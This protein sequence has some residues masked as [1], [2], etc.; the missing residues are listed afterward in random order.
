MDF[1]DSDF[2]K[3]RE[4]SKNFSSLSSQKMMWLVLLTLLINFKTASTAHVRQQMYS[5]AQCLSLYM[6]D[7]SAQAPNAQEAYA[8]AQAAAVAASEAEE[9]KIKSSSL[10][11][12][13]HSVQRNQLVSCMSKSSNIVEPC[14][15]ALPHALTLVKAHL[16]REAKSWFNSECDQLK[17]RLTNNVAI[18]NNG[19]IPEG[20]AGVTAI[21]T[22]VA[23]CQ[24]ATTKLNEYLIDRDKHIEG[25]LHMNLDTMTPEEKAKAKIQCQSSQQLFKD[26]DVAVSGLWGDCQGRIAALLHRLNDAID[27]KWLYPNGI[28]D[29][30]G[31][32]LSSSSSNS[33]IQTVC[34]TLTGKTSEGTTVTPYEKKAMTGAMMALSESE[35]LEMEAHE[36]CAKLLD[37]ASKI[38]YDEEEMK[39]NVKIYDVLMKNEERSYICEPIPESCDNELLPV[40]NPTTNKCEACPVETPPLHWDPVEMKCVVRQHK[41]SITIIKLVCPGEQFQDPLDAEQCKCPD[42]RPKYVGYKGLCCKAD[43]MYDTLTEKCG[44]PPPICEGQKNHR[45]PV[46]GV[47]ECPAKLPHYLKGTCSQCPYP[48]IRYIR[49]GG[50]VDHPKCERST[51]EAG[52]SHLLPGTNPTSAEYS[53]GAT[54]VAG[55]NGGGTVSL[56]QT[57]DTSEQQRAQTMTAS[58]RSSNKVEEEVFASSA[59]GTAAEGRGQG[60]EDF[61][62]AATGSDQSPNNSPNN[63]GSKGNKNSKTARLLSQQAEDIKRG[64]SCACPYEYPH[65]VGGQC[66]NCCA[67]EKGRTKFVPDDLNDLA[68]SGRCECPNEVENVLSY[69]SGKA[70]CG[71][72]PADISDHSVKSRFVSITEGAS[73]GECQCELSHPHTDTNDKCIQ[74]RENEHWDAE[75]K[76]CSET[77]CCGMENHPA[78]NTCVCPD[79][80][81]HLINGKC[82]K[83]SSIKGETTKWVAITRTVEENTNNPNMNDASTGEN[84]KK[85]EEERDEREGKCVCPDEAHTIRLPGAD[86]DTCLICDD[87]AF[88]FFNILTMRCEV[89][90]TG[91]Q[92]FDVTTNKCACPKEKSLWIAGTCF[93][94]CPAEEQPKPEP[95]HGCV[96]KEFVVDDQELMTTKTPVKL[97]QLCKKNAMEKKARGFTLYSAT[98]DEI[99]SR[100]ALCTT[101]HNLRTEATSVGTWFLGVHGFTIHTTELVQRTNF[102]LIDE[103][104]GDGVCRCPE[105]TP[106]W[107]ELLK[108]CIKCDSEKT[109]FNKEEGMCEK[110]CDEAEGLQWNAAKQKCACPTDDEHVIVSKDG[111]KRCNICESPQDVFY[112]MVESPIV[113][114]QCG[115]PEGEE[116]WEPPVTKETPQTSEENPESSST[117]A[118]SVLPP[119]KCVKCVAPK[120][121]LDPLTGECTKE[122]TEGKVFS[123]EH[124]ICEC[125]EV[126]PCFAPDPVTSIPRC[127]KC[128]GNTMCT[129]FK[130]TSDIAFGAPKEVTGGPEDSP[131]P[132]TFHFGLSY[133]IHTF[134]SHDGGDICLCQCPKQLPHR[135]GNYDDGNCIACN[136]PKETFDETLKTCVPNCDYEGQ[137]GDECSCPEGE[138]V[139]DSSGHKDVQ[140][141]CSLCPEPTNHF[142]PDHSKQP[143]GVGTCHCPI[144]THFVD[145]ITKETITVPAC[146]A[147]TEPTSHFDADSQRCVGLCAHGQVWITNRCECPRMEPNTP[148]YVKDG[149]ENPICLLC[150]SDGSGATDFTVINEVTGE[151]ECKCPEE[152][153]HMGIVDG[154]VPESQCMACEVDGTEFNKDVQKCAPICAKGT[155][156]NKEHMACECPE[157]VP[158]TVRTTDGSDS[159]GQCVAPRIR[160]EV[161][162]DG[163]D[164]KK[165]VDCPGWPCFSLPKC[166]GGTEQSVCDDRLAQYDKCRVC[167]T[168]VE[169]ARKRRPDIDVGKCACPEGKEY[170]EKAD[171]CVGPCVHPQEYNPAKEICEEPPAVCENGKINAPEGSPTEGECVCPD[172][173]PHFLGTLCGTC[174][175]PRIRFESDNIPADDIGTCQCPHHA[176][177]W[178]TVAQEC[179]GCP[180]G[181]DWT[182]DVDLG[183]G[184]ECRKECG[185]EYVWKPGST[186]PE[187]GMCVCPEGKP[188]NVHGKCVDC[189]TNGG[190]NTFHEIECS[191]QHGSHSRR[192][193]LLER[194]AEKTT[195]M[196]VDV[197]ALKC[198]VCD[199][200]V[201]KPHYNGPQ[202][203]CVQCDNPR[204]PH[205]DDEYEE[206]VSPCHGGQIFMP[207]YDECVCNPPT[208][209]IATEGRCGQGCPEERPELDRS[210]GLCRRRKY[211]DCNPPFIDPVSQEC[212][213]GT[214]TEVTWQK[215]SAK[216]CQMYIS[217]LVTYREVQSIAIGAYQMNKGKLPMNVR[218]G[219][220]KDTGTDPTKAAGYK[221][222]L[223]NW[224][225]PAGDARAYFYNLPSTCNQCMAQ[226]PFPKGTNCADMGCECNNLIDPYNE[227]PHYGDVINDEGLSMYVTLMSPETWKRSCK[228][229]HTKST[230]KNAVAADWK[231][232]LKIPKALLEYG[233]PVPLPRFKVP[234]SE[235]FW[236]CPAPWV[237]LPGTIMKVGGQRGR[238][239]E[240]QVSSKA[241]TP[242]TPTQ[243]VANTVAVSTSSRARMRG[244][245]SMVAKVHQKAKQTLTESEIRDQQ[246]EEK[247]KAMRFGR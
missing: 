236:T 121:Q 61:V 52:E 30:L 54:G 144:G 153:P 31:G 69:S 17:V 12:T 78:T 222:I 111:T 192:L 97:Y 120:D 42:E 148:H 217:G 220:M 150:G 55:I 123:E 25:L 232:N 175:E 20:S 202:D 228:T 116:Y 107:S 142:V 91:G 99:K 24:E 177:H 141:E 64:G 27:Q 112:P 71:A 225:G 131:N 89:E 75:K 224:R 98:N 180:E 161:M 149:G 169:E 50:E 162:D 115:C 44:D 122:C 3:L 193:L 70:M 102:E 160:F 8:M 233:I 109:I 118:V 39:E 203:K 221:D 32:G 216:I 172:D 176:I 129:E 22:T 154:A 103:L 146:I 53:L 86:H 58:S 47:C 179:I 137:T 155:I 170:G 36:N 113:E 127:F 186:G 15:K 110:K 230:S 85:E 56:L 163:S 92:V 178:N 213:Q 130:P 48:R 74:C 245:M 67:D 196:S 95:N 200:P 247:R 231:C 136:E 226:T 139:I 66:I 90:C 104:M 195:K 4:E 234:N 206:C 184:G 9:G 117:E 68:G 201:E 214:M 57:A 94:T 76:V 166:T 87:V 241:T 126:T 73:E 26:Q 23:V 60:E 106:E 108:T 135:A 159:C 194:K 140:P 35:K 132:Q 100:C 198:G 235:A 125:P 157:D 164:V 238:F 38:Q 59:T 211:T 79:A 173:K 185:G 212:K 105:E 45:D 219:M 21:T 34:D 80:L 210:T 239:K 114:G 28:Y 182:F 208:V 1:D 40:L 93:S 167:Q 246:L 7:Q 65:F 183:N 13:F 145:R 181:D 10:I 88:P 168:E 209:W 207:E 229:I 124:Q 6:L 49:E 41:S 188:H 151:G 171:V 191:K 205:W 37:S 204:K 96:E 119:A 189:A 134:D 16:K 199:C 197:G 237:P 156:L 77:C 133:P 158:H 29:K 147:C 165:V 215:R 11:E 242:T 128:P 244:T 51:Q 187:S 83:C 240:V 14:P 19:K 82:D 46:T 152:A 174:M 5:P 72:C 243:R 101:N 190:R 223:K 227:C 143:N 138:H 62:A 84:K 43:Q 18:G 81:P 218:E 63:K 33:D 2:H